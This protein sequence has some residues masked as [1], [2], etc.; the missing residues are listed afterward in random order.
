METIQTILLAMIQGLTEFLPISSS[1]HLIL[2]SEILGWNDQGLIF[3]I[4][5][6]FGTLLAV[7]FYFKNDIYQ[8]FSHSH[9]KD[10]STLINSTLGVITIATLPIVIVGG[11]FSGF[12]EENLRSPFVIALAT[13]F[14]GVLLYLSDRKAHLAIGERVMTVSLGFI[15]GLSQILAVIPGTSRSG[16]TITAALFLGFSRTEAARFSFLLSIPVIIAGNILGIY[17]FSQIEDMI[18]DY[19]DLLLGIGVSFVI[20]YLTIKWF[21]NFVEK[22]G[23]LP[24]VVYR[25]FLGVIIFLYIY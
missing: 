7:I 22:I 4:S 16:I 15:I 17:E 8:M 11:L 20:A 21:I 24:F 3:D 25:L 9:F 14:F 10:F 6:H 19:S 12:I 13:I 2:L 23:M 18:F 5:L 1:A